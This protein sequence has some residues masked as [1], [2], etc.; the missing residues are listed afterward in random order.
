M[1]FN[2]L[3]LKYALDGSSNYIAWKD[4]IETVLE[5]KCLK[6]FIDQEVPKLAVTNTQELVEQKKC[7]ARVRRILLGGVRDHIISSLHWKKTP[8][9]MWKT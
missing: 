9:S 5:K 8:F 7:V 1:A 6:D 3:R 2:S 4:H